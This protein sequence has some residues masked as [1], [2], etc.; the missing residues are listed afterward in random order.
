MHFTVDGSRSTGGFS[1]ASGHGVLRG[2][3]EMTTQVAAGCG[4]Q[5]TV[6]GVGL[7]CERSELD[8]NG[9]LRL[10]G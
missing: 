10:A 6:P 9:S 7:V 2:F 4:V 1:G 8:I 3:D 5:H